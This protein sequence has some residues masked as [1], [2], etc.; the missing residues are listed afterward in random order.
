MAEAAP[1][2][3]PKS[4]ATCGSNGSVTRNEAPLAKAASAMRAMERVSARSDAAGEGEDTLTPAGWRA[5]Y[6]MI[7]KSGTRF[8]KRSCAGK[9]LEAH[10]SSARDSLQRQP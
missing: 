10:R 1:T 5:F 2:L 3:E 4:S 9:M 8:R 7:P 6:R